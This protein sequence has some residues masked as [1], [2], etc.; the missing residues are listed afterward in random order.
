MYD[1]ILV[2]TDGSDRSEKALE[3][4]ETVAETHSAELHIVNVIDQR[5][6]NLNGMAPSAVNQLEKARI[7]MVEDQQEEAEEEGLDVKAD[8][9]H[10]VPHEEIADYVEEH[11]IDGIIIG[12]TGNTGIDN[13]LLGSTADK[14]LRTTDVPVTVV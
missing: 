5:N 6:D 4:A 8:V 7:E 11:D 10:G 14:V 1:K 12:S 2:P 13:L 9:V 3:M